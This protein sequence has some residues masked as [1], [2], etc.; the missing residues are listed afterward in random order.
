MRKGL[1]E[2]E[3]DGNL[4]HHPFSEDGFIADL[5]SCRAVIAGSGFTLILRLVEQSK[6]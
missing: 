6:S 2:E 1:Q 4:R 5:A 3:V